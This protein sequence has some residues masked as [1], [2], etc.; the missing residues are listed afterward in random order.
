[1]DQSRVGPGNMEVLPYDAGT[2]PRTPHGRTTRNAAFVYLLVFAV[3]PLVRTSS[4]G[5]YGGQ[6]GSC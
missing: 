5:T 4:S 2:I 6:C 1:M 3:I